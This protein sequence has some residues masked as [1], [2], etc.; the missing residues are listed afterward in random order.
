MP[1]VYIAGPMRGYPNLNFEAFD[2]AAQAWEARGWVAINPAQMDREV[3][4]TGAMQTSA[5]GTKGKD[6]EEAMN[7]DLPA[8][9]R[10]QAIALLPGWEKS[11]GATTELDRARKLGHDVYD[12]VTFQ[13]LEGSG[14]TAVRSFA[15]TA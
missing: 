12:A 8:V 3:G 6:F 2:A 11:A 7:R 5:P 13:L 1:T 9:T 15:A 14:A 10:S 4:L